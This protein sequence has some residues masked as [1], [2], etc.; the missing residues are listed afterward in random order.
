M[1][2]FI[3]GA[4]GMVGTR[5][6]ES[7]LSKD[8]EVVV[9]TRNSDLAGKYF[10]RRNKSVSMEIIEGDITEKGVWQEV[11]AECD[12]IVH[13]AGAGIVDCRWTKSYK[14]I[15]K[16]SRI[17]STKNVAA[18]ARKT[19][20]C[21]G[22]TGFYGDRGDQNLT[23]MSSGGD[24]FLAD[25]CKEWEQAASDAV[26]RVVCLRFGMVLDSSGGVLAKMQRFF[27]YGLGGSLGSGK[28]YWPWIA[29]QDACNIIQNAI[30][31]QWEGPINAVA[32]EQVTCKEFVQTLGGVLKRPSIV[33]VP[34]FVLKIALGESHGVLIGSQRVTPTLLI[35]E[36]FAFEYPI[37]R[38]AFRVILEDYNTN[39]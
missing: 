38:D 27:M 5:L 36:G 15:L 37:L 18:V 17:D 28:Q 29:R 33:R 31:Q 26:G 25:L 12:A 9:I 8:H 22:A 23:E 13:L 10:K 6:V 1:R 11:A 7:L 4:T 30:Y 39:V 34:K 24:G 2:I 20:V 3:T 32:P 19:L 16:K 14:K 35:Q 21:A